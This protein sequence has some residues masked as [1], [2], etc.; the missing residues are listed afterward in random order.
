LARARSSISSEKS[1]PITS[2]SGPTRRASS[3]A[4]SPVPQATSS[5]LSPAASAARSAA[6]ERQR[7]CRPTV[8]TEFMTS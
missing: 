2:P 6:R 7:W 8:M 1:E 3:M 5:A 4:R